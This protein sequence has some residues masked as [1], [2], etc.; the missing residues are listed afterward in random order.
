MGAPKESEFQVTIDHTKI[1]IRFDPTHQRMSGVAVHGNTPF[2]VPFISKVY[3]D[4]W[5][6]G[7]QSGLRLPTFIDHL[8]SL[9]PWE[10]YHEGHELKSRLVVRMYD[11]L[12]G[13]NRDEVEGVA[14]WIN[15]ARK[16]GT[17]LVHC[18]AGLNRSGLV[19][20]AALI[21]EGMP[22][23][24]AIQTLREARSDAVLCNPSFASWL[25]KFEEDKV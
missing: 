1:D 4:L 18:Q 5:Q 6:G 14:R 23:K 11:D 9:Y 24:E 12:A 3:D 16:T 10:Q 22:A 21:L 2:D 17:V 8:V 13:P 25:E 19:T 20:A 15:A 7:C